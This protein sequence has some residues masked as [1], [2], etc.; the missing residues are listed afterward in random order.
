MG[1]AYCK[2]VNFQSISL[3]Y[4]ITIKVF[5][6][7]EDVVI[8]DVEIFRGMPL[9]MNPIPIVKMPTLRGKF[10]WKKLGVLIEES[11]KNIPIYKRYVNEGFAW[12]SLPEYK[13]REW[14]A[15]VDLKDKI[16]PP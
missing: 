16:G 14:N 5:D 4:G 2:I 13:S 12:E 7:F 15:F 6:Y 1:V 11:D 10:A 9:F 8:K 3:Y